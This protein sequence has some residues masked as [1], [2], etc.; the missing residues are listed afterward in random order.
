MLNSIGQSVRSGENADRGGTVVDN[1]F[2]GSKE[3]TMQC[4]EDAEEPP[5]V[6]TEKFSKLQVHLNA[7]T[8]H[9]SIGLKNGCEA[10][11]EK[12][13]PKLG[14]DALYK[15]T[16]KLSSLPY[17]LTVQFVRFEFVVHSQKKTKIIR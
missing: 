8:T 5:T 3:V 14:R 9:V 15:K 4:Q 11:V 16:S 7:Q 10:E 6:Q 2:Y 17:Y 12:N 13:S 1:L